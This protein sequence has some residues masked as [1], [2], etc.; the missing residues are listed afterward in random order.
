MYISY[1]LYILL[2]YCDNFVIIFC[3]EFPSFLVFARALLKKLS[4]C[5]SNSDFLIP[6]SAK[7]NIEDLRYF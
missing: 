3:K 4:N 2:D 6:I 5:A 1:I 7:L